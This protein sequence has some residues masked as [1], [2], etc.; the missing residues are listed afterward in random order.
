MDAGPGA[1]CTGRVKG[2]RG[3]WLKSKSSVEV[4]EDRV[5]LAHVGPGVGAAVGGGIE[6]GAV[7]EVVLDEL[8]VGV[9]AEDLVVDVALLGVGADHDPGHAQAE[10]VAVDDRRHDMVVEAAPVIPGEEDRGAVPV[11]AVA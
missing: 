1:G 9:E 3:V 8:G 10:A 6:P 5:V 7:E 11:G 4:A 2:G